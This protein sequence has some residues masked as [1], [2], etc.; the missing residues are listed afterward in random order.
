MVQEVNKCQLSSNTG[1]VF[2]ALPYSTANTSSDGFFHEA[3]SRAWIGI[4]TAPEL[5]AVH[6]KEF[7][8]SFWAY[9][10]VF[11]QHIII[12]KKKKPNTNSNPHRRITCKT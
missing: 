1:L 6:Q 11:V 10:C 7:W 9:L 2:Q 5:P 12:L 3:L 4:W 8:N